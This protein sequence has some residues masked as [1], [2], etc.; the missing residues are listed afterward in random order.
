LLKCRNAITT[1]S[2]SFA[3][4]HLGKMHEESHSTLFEDH[5]LP[6]SA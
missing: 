3:E 5:F 1:V 2:L 6:H 4:S